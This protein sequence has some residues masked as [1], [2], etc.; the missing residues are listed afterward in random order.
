MRQQTGVSEVKTVVAQVQQFC[1][2][3]LSRRRV[4]LFAFCK[5]ARLNN[6]VFGRLLVRH[7][8]IQQIVR[9]HSYSETV[10]SVQFG[11]KRICQ[12]II[13]YVQL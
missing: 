13:L 11:V 3:C 6:R 8:P 9:I 10:L 5:Q 12:R 1:V 4:R 2:P 7:R